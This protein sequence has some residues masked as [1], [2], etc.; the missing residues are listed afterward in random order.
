MCTTYLEAPVTYKAGVHTVSVDEK[1]G[2]Q[3]L[4]HL[5]PVK[6]TRPGLVER[7]EFEYLRHGTLSLIA[8]FEVAL[9]QVR[10]IAFIFQLR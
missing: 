5:Y 4:E 2:I 1:T 6:P 7:R 10:A 8:S 3:A 9:G